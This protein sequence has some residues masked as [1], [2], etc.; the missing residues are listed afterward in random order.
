MLK[1]AGSSFILPSVNNMQ[2]HNEC[3]YEFYYNVCVSNRLCSVLQI[4]DLCFSQF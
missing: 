2:L 3:N 4:L 1:A